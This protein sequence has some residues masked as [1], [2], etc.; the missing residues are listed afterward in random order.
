[1]LI[2]NTNGINYNFYEHPY[3]SLSG[4]VHVDTAVNGQN[5]TA[6]PPLTGVTV[7]LLDS[8]GN[9]IQ[10]T[11]TNASGGYTF[12]QLTPG[13]YSVR[14]LSVDGYYFEVAFAGSVGGTAADN[15]DVDTITLPMAVD[16]QQ[17]NFYVVPPGSI[18]GHVHIDVDGQCET[19]PNEPGLAGVTVQLQN[20]RDRSSPP[21]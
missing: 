15:H 3:S 1:M 10:T 8:N 12:S 5:N 14:E 16:A 13:T 6:D 11:Q 9:V 4:S 20:Q 17:Y 21:P 7:Q 2:S 19:N 18:G